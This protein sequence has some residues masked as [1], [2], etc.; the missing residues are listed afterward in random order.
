MTSRLE[1][2]V[3]EAPTEMS[4]EKEAKDQGMITIKQDGILKVLQG[5]TSLEEVL[6]VVE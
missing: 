6:K 5:V 1:K 2:I 4:I 3:V